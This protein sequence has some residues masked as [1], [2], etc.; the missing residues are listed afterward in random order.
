MISYNSIKN[1]FSINSIILSISFLQVSLN[2]TSFF[3]NF[4]FL[5]SKNYLLIEGIDY[6]TKDLPKIQD[7][8]LHE[9]YPYEFVLFLFSSPLIETITHL[10]I[11]NTIFYDFVSYDI[12]N[13]SYDLSTFIFISFLFEIIFDFFHY[14]T[15]L[16]VH[17]NKLLYQN[18]H[19]T[20]HKFS[21]PSC[22]TTFY[23]HPVDIII[24]NSIPLLFTLYITHLCNIFPS[25]FQYSLIMLYKSFVEIS[26][27]SGRRIKASSFTQ[28]I[29]L[30]RFFNIHLLVD[31]HD[32]HHSFNNCNYAKRFT[33][34]D[35]CF[36]TYTKISA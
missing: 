7:L 9:S 29:W 31:D 1:F 34:W 20:H 22:I 11:K 4:A 24:T 18:F 10:F 6:S 14:W 28:C 3:F 15:H 17:K 8:Q 30:P 25:Y 12:S 16:L 23:Q 33:L 35:K 27:H 5:L 13:L 36:G 21:N 2:I 26:G 19:K 32:A